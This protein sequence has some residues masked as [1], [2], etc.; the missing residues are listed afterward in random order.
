MKKLRIGR[1]PL[2]NKIYIGSVGK[3]PGLWLSD[4][5]DATTEA[6]LAVAEHIGVGFVQTFTR[7]DGG[8]SLQIEVR[9]VPAEASAA[10]AQGGHHEA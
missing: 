1:S 6:V 9:E 10:L 5:T 3:D 7:K 4:Q 2:T 8:P